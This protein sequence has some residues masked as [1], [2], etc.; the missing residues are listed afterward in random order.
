MHATPAPAPRT[1]TRTIVRA[2]SGVTL[3]EIMIVLAIIALIMGFLVGP[4]VIA[5]LKEAR[6][7]TAWMMS[8]QFE[9]AYGKWISDHDDTCPA[10]LEDL[11]KYT[12]KKDIKDPWG[13][14]F[15]MK[16][17]EGAPEDSE[18]GVLSRGPDKKEGSEDDV[19]S[20]EKPKR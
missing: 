2:Q 15:I 20:W 10:A 8:K 12:N 13:Q 6:V 1:T 14:D 18:F 11:A 19:K 16:C 5:Y 17:G 3:I 7:K 4:R 9:E